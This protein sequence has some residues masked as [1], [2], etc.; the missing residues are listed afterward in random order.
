MQA[1]LE[2]FTLARLGL[3]L[4]VVGTLM[5]AWSFGKNLEEAHQF[6]EKGRKVYLASFLRPRCFTWG[7]V[8]IVLGFV[9]Q[10]VG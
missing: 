4:N 9:L 10:F 2:F 6:D 1:V 3:L 7:M 5:I 8:I